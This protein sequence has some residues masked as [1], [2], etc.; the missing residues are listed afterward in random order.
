MKNEKNKSQ[1]GEPGQSEK[2]AIVRLNDMADMIGLLTWLGRKTRHGDRPHPTDQWGF[3]RQYVTR[4]APSTDPQEVIDLLRSTSS[5]ESEVQAALWLA[6][7][8][9][10]IP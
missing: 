4:Y 9:E 5:T 3:T 10:D 6:L 7:R 1:S 2:A 8:Q